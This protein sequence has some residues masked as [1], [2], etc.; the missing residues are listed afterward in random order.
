MDFEEEPLPREEDPLA[1]EEHPLGDGD[2]AMQ[3]VEFCAV[4]IDESS[5]ASSFQSFH[6]SQYK[7]LFISDVNF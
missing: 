5:Y 1:C 6:S 2:D 3:P 4:M 7:F